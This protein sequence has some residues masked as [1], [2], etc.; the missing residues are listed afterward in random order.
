MDQGPSS[1]AS[2]ASSFSF[3]SSSCAEPV[4]ALLRRVLPEALLC[5]PQFPFFG[6]A[7]SSPLSSA[8][9]HVSRTLPLMSLGSG[10]VQI[11]ALP[12]RRLPRK[13]H[14]THSSPEGCTPP[15]PSTL[16]F[17]RR[18]CH[19]CHYHPLGT[20]V[21]TRVPSL[22]SSVFR[23]CA[24]LALPPRCP[25]LPHP[26]P[27]TPSRIIVFI[28]AGHALLPLPGCQPG[29]QCLCIPSS[30][31]PS[32]TAPAWLGVSAL[33]SQPASLFTEIIHL[34]TI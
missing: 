14:H 16:L 6:E 7:L 19:I 11:P 13:S 27:V 30:R 20:Q 12:T 26:D 28:H 15:L 23:T 32:Q 2:A 34:H 8:T 25:P 31:K 17:A 22:K 18:L 10:S 21:G 24:G 29:S 5:P 9:I 4:H 33:Y 1:G 3:G